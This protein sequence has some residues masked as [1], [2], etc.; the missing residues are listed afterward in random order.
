MSDLEYI[1]DEVDFKPSETTPPAKKTAWS[2]G[3][4]GSVKD[5]NSYA[6]GLCHHFFTIP[7]IYCHNQKILKS[8]FTKEPASKEVCLVN[9]Y[10]ATG[11]NA[12]SA[13]SSIYSS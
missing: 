7:H 2:K 13:L 6:H 4:Q 9:G 5:P 12:Q 8:C 1:S 10:Y 3:P 11:D